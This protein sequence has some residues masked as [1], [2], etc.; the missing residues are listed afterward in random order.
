MHLVICCHVH[1]AKMCI[2][3][4]S[5]I[6]PKCPSEWVSE[7]GT[8]SDSSPVC[9]PTERRTSPA[10]GN[11]DLDVRGG[12]ARHVSISDTGQ[13]IPSEHLPYI[14]ERFYRVDPSRSRVTG[15]TGLGL[16]ITKHLVEAHG[17]RISVQSEVGKGT[18]FSFTVPIAGSDPRGPGGDTSD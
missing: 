9:P 3:M 11:V 17:G 1:R 6:A 4:R 7:R 12:E 8:A 14:F 18:R 15:G 5:G 10:A 16:A 13:G 2:E